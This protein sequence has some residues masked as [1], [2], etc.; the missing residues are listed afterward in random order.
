[1][2]ENRRY[3]KHACLGW[4][5]LRIVFNF[6]N[7]ACLVRFTMLTEYWLGLVVWLAFANALYCLGPALDIYAYTV[8]GFRLGL[9]RYLLFVAGLIFLWRWWLFLGRLFPL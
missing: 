3:L 6:V 9:G 4:E 1:M 8:L 2:D 5:M 7:V